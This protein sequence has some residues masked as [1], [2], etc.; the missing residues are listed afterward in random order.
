M[1]QHI[2]I[3][4]SDKVFQLKQEKKNFNIGYTIKLLSLRTISQRWNIIYGVSENVNDFENKIYSWF[5]YYLFLYQ[6]QTIKKQKEIIFVEHS[7]ISSIIY[8]FYNFRL[9]LLNIKAL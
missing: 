7:F 3:K 6:T 8:F 1:D 5:Y 9:Y 2:N 4:T